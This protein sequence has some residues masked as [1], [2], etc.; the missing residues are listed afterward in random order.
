MT[1]LKIPKYNN[2]GKKF[3]IPIK[4]YSYDQLLKENTENKIK[5]SILNNKLKQYEDIK[6]KYN[7]IIENKDNENLSKI[8]NKSIY[9]ESLITEGKYDEINTERTISNNNFTE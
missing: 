9:L 5:I 4:K 8:N 6:K 7:E 2:K 1:K 3:E